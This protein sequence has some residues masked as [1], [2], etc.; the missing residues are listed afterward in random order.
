MSEIR[1][2]SVHD[3]PEMV[4]LAK[5]VHAGNRLAKL[6]FDG[7]KLAEQLISILDP[8]NS[9]YCFFVGEVPDAGISGGLLGYVTGCLFSEALVTTNYVYFVNP[10]YRGSSLAIRLI[11]AFRKWA[12]NRGTTLFCISQNA[13]IETQRFDKFMKKIGL[14]CTGGNFSKLITDKEKPTVSTLQRISGA[15]QNRSY[16]ENCK[17][18]FATVSDIP[19]LIRIGN[20]IH[21]ESSMARLAFSA[22]IFGTFIRNMLNEPVK[23]IYCVLIAENESGITGLLT[24]YINEYLNFRRGEI[25]VTYCNY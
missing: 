6:P 5:S 21:S 2:A 3:I 4:N 20:R 24:G 9:R 10:E 12:Q 1:F 19:E 18:R 14:K 23:G 25:F 15:I 11:T 13:A 17:I 7:N 16:N 8:P 22:E